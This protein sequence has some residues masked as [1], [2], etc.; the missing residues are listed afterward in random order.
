MKRSVGLISS[1]PSIFSRSKS[2]SD[3]SAKDQNGRQVDVVIEMRDDPAKARITQWPCRKAN[4]PPA[5]PV[6]VFTGEARGGDPMWYSTVYLITN[7]LVS[8][9][10]L[11]RWY[12]EYLHSRYVKR[13]GNVREVHFRVAPDVIALRHFRKP[14]EAQSEPS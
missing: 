7:N 2:I 4:P 12:R 6:R 14:G 11:L 13:I 5:Q 9:S 8:L 3:R 1:N 10:I